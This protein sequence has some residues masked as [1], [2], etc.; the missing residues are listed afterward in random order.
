VNGITLRAPGTSLDGRPLGE[1]LLDIGGARIR[2][3]R[4]GC[5]LL[6]DDGSAGVHVNGRPVRRCAL[7]RPGDHLHLRGNAVLLAGGPVDPAPAPATGATSSGTS[8]DARVLLRAVGG[9]H[10]GRGFPLGRGR[11]VGSD[12]AADIRLDAPLAGR[13][14]RISIE[15]GKVVLRGLSSGTSMVNGEAV[16]DAE[17]RPG[18]QVLFGGGD[19]F[20]LEAPAAA[21]ALPDAPEPPAVFDLSAG[22]RARRLPWLLLAAL[23]IA[24]ALSALLLL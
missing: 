14:A 8:D 2:F 18:D 23:L 17:L 9:R 7:L 15:A 11:V 13:H 24:A 22:Q 16:R 5:W 19:R 6:V 10:H 21:P 3:D 20:V 12:P 4:R 1:G